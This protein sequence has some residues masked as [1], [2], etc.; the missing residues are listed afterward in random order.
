MCAGKL[1][2]SRHPLL[3]CHL[4]CW[5]QLCWM[6]LLGLKGLID[7]RSSGSRARLQL[8]QRHVLAQLNA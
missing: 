8:K 4:Q 5:Q 2:H 3:L 7:L 6:L 1:P